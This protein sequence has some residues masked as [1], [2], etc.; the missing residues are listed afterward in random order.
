MSAAGIAGEPIDS[1]A[2]QAIM[3]R[4]KLAEQ[5]LL[6]SPD[7]SDEGKMAIHVLVSHDIPR[8]LFELQHLRTDLKSFSARS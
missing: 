2:L 6:E 8:L 4:W 3:I 7:G 1:S 5:Y